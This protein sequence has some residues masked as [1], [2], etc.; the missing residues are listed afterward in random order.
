KN[1]PNASQTPIDTLLTV[2]APALKKSSPPIKHAVYFEFNKAHLTVESLQEL[3]F[4]INNV[5][6]NHADSIL[7]VEIVGY[8]DQIGS[9]K[10]N[11]QLSEKRAKTVAV[12]LKE[13]G[14]RVDRVYIEGGGE[15][16]DTSIPDEM[17]RKVEVIFRLE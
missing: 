15:I 10:Y 9:N 8:S 7:E 6:P 1:L 17:K 14:I 2:D 11:L 4:F 3:Q 12:Y 13:K 5:L 16:D